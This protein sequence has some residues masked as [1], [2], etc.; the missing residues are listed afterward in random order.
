[1][2]MDLYFPNLLNTLCLTGL[3]DMSENLMWKSSSASPG[4][5]GVK[6]TSSLILSK[7]PICPSLTLG[8]VH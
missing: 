6:T 3:L 7:G 8:S 2:S 5:V 1:M 4:M